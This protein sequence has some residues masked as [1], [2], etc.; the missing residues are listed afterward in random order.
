MNPPVRI[1]WTGRIAGYLCDFNHPIEHRDRIF[2]IPRSADDYSTFRHE[3][4]G[5]ISIGAHPSLRH[6]WNEAIVHYDR[7]PTL[8]R[9]IQIGE[10]DHGIWIAGRVNL[11]NWMWHYH[12][13]QPDLSPDWRQ[14]GGHLDLVAILAIAKPK[15][16]FAGR[17]A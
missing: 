11:W 2:N 17:Q 1:K 16:V 9:H 4:Q 12:F 14:L 3:G 7:L 5:R 13:K 8:A 6:P 15:I 10:D